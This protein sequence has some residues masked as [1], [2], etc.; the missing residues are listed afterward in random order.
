MRESFA[1]LNDFAEVPAQTSFA[2]AP[3]NSLM[4]LQRKLGQAASGR[5]GPVPTDLSEAGVV[6]LARAGV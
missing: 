6:R 3:S 1:A 4:F 5:P 2:F